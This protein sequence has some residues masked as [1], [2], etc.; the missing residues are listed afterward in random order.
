MVWVAG[1]G[2]I[3]ACRLVL[4]ASRAWLVASSGGQGRPGR[5]SPL[6]ACISCHSNVN[7]LPLHPLLQLPPQHL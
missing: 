1:C 5:R 6:V 3:L 2:Y 7:P 4:P